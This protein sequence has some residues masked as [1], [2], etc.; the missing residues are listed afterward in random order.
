MIDSEAT[1]SSKEAAR[2]ID[3]LWGVGK[4]E[5]MKNACE[6]SIKISSISSQKGAKKAKGATEYNGARKWKR[7]DELQRSEV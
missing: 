2:S 1:A 3:A 5:G 6:W 4:G 7:S